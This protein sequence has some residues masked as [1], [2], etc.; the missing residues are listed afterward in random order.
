MKVSKT[1]TLT[2]TT[3][4]KLQCPVVRIPT[5]TAVISRDY[6]KIENDENTK[7]LLRAFY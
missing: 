3:I 1:R 6:S 2:I 5:F 4:K 7:Q